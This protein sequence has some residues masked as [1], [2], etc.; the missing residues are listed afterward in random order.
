M[1]VRPKEP[2]RASPAPIEP[3]PA[4]FGRPAA[5]GDVLTLRCG[6]IAAGGG[7][8]ARA[9]DGRVVF[10]RHSLPDELVEAEIMSE[11]TTYLRADAI[12]VLEPSPD[13]VEPRCPHAGPGRCGGCDF[14]HVD[15]AAQRTLKAARIADQLRRLARIEPTIE[16]EPV[17]GAPDGLG[18]RTR[19]RYAVDAEGHLGLH[20]YRSHT[21]ERIERCPIASD[22][23]NAIGA[24]ATRW[25]GIDAVEVVATEPEERRRTDRGSPNDALGVIVLTPGRSG[26][27]LRDL[28]RSGPAN[29]G[30]VAGREV[31]REP[32]A[33]RADALGHSFHISA[34]SFWQIHRGAPSVLAEAVLAGLEPV[35]GEF[36][37]DLYAGVGLFSVLLSLAVGD[38]G[39]V[40]AIERNRLACADARR[41][42]QGNP[43]IEVREAEVTPRLVA[44][45]ARPQLMVLD[46]P[47]EGAGRA[48]M[49][50]ITEL[51]PAPRR[52]AYVACDPSSFARDLRVVLDAGWRLR[53][54][55]AFDQFPMTEH[56]EIVAILDP[57][58][59]STS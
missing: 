1:T 56:V 28:A 20:R 7:C 50:A 5:I 11:N 45:I 34:G 17:P 37:L 51:R 8:V 16:V 54:I 48:V 39:R 10:V 26:A 3:P 55:R 40:L 24:A 4:A 38:H 13:R 27:R 44:S 9:A 49:G 57:A 31:L 23:L 25:P 41:N 15:L 12:R 46:P 30:V 14:Q 59:R 6:E 2:E 47:R 32:H 52:V 42:A 19:M 21:I 36:V 43:R 35:P 58:T 22:A 33:L 53:S 18:W 29:T